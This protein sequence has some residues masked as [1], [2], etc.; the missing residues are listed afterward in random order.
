MSG[1]SLETARS[2]NAVTDEVPSVD[3]KQGEDSLLL[4]WDQVPE[5][6]QD[7]RYILTGY[8]RVT[9]SY[10]RAIVSLAYLHNQTGDI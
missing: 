7:N 5:W 9:H 4:H 6:Q 8:R 3:P 10:Q 2:D 1:Q